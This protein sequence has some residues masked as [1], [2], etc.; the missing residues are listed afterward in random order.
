M[1]VLVLTVFEQITQILKYSHNQDFAF[2]SAR[3][4][5]SYLS[6]PWR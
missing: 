1:Y 2:D 3:I 6:T 5:A 4:F